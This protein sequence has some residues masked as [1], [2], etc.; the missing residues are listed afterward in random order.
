MYIKSPCPKKRILAFLEGTNQNGT[1]F[2]S[3][4]LSL[5]HIRSTRAALGA[6]WRCAR[7]ATFRPW[8]CQN[9]LCW[10]LAQQAKAKLSPEVSMGSR[11]VLI[12][13]L[14]GGK[15]SI[16]YGD[17]V[18]KCTVL[19]V[20]VFFVG[21]NKTSKAKVWRMERQMW[22]VMYFNCVTR[23][24]AFFCQC[25][26][27]SLILPQNLDRPMPAIVL[28]PGLGFQK[29]IQQNSPKQSKDGWVHTSQGI[30]HV[31]P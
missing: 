16:L 7:L 14:F 29:S 8:L 31:G 18:K 2:L 9:Q 5:I 26:W 10:A 27:I 28:P 25:Q 24:H 4:S 23:V 6:C 21:W 11:M 13:P 15:C 3:I 20:G 17:V 30:H 1:Q 12:L 22:G 19:R